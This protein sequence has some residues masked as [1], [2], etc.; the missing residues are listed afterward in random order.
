MDSNSVLI[1]VLFF[2]LTGW[3]ATCY[4]V[5]SS[6]FKPHTRR[7]LIIPLWFPWMLLALGGPVVQGIV[8]HTQALSSG[9]GL[10]IGMLSVIL[11]HRLMRRRSR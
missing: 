8:P 10:T 3:L 1:Q 7:F 6:R 5:V 9:I 2:A 11:M 4:W